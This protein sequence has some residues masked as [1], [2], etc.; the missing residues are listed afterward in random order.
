LKGSGKVG[1]IQETPAG[2][3]NVCR[4]HARPKDRFDQGNTEGLSQVKKE[5][6]SC[7][8]PVVALGVCLVL[9]MLMVCTKIVQSVE[10]LVM[11]IKYESCP[12]CY[13]KAVEEKEIRGNVVIFCNECHNKIDTYPKE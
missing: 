11:P 4:R 13:S 1:L 8:L 7:A 9:M 12:F 2:D 6:Q 5:S 10:E 3:R